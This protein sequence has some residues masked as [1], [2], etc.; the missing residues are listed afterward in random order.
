MDALIGTFHIDIK[1]VIF[2][3]VN[4]AVVFF[5]LYKFAIKPISKL[6]DE[7]KSEIDTG[8]SD[9]QESKILKEKMLSDY[10]AEMTKAR[11]ESQSLFEEMKKDVENQRTALISGA[12]TEVEAMIKNGREQ[13][14]QEKQKMMNEIKSEIVDLVVLATS[15]VASMDTSDVQVQSKIKE[16]IETLA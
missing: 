11:T 2:Q 13:L 6:M 3:L 5:V 14:V 12:H 16:A 9:A 15:K 7:R 4:F 1:M 10:K 8:I